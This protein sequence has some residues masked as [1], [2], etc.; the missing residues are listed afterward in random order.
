MQQLPELEDDMQTL[1]QQWMQE[2]AERDAPKYREEGREEGREEVA[3]NMLKHGADIEFVI[4]SSGLSR[5][6]VEALFARHS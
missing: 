1:A 4:K 3:L 2:G 5:E 6:A